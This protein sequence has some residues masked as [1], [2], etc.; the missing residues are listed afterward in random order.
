[1][2]NRSVIPLVPTFRLAALPL[3]L[4]AIGCGGDEVRPAPASNAPAAAPA[5]V[6]AVTFETR[7]PS[8]GRKAPPRR[9]SL[10]R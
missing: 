4:C 3:L 8:S 1:M 7:V 6:T 9:A 5:A 2:L 10:T